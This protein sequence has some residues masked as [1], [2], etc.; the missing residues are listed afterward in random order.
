MSIEGFLNFGKGKIADYKAEAVEFAESD[1]GQALIGLANEAK[2]HVSQ[3][4]LVRRFGGMAGTLATGM[5]VLNTTID[6]GQIID[7]TRNLDPIDFADTAAHLVLEAPLTMWAFDK[8]FSRRNAENFED[9]TILLPDQ[10]LTL[11]LTPQEPQTF[12]LQEPELHLLQT[13]S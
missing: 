4:R 13:P 7:D 2:D 8:K 11:D 1:N 6:S 5:L 9:G 3:Y 10:F 12:S